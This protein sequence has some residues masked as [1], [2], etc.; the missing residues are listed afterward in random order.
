MPDARVFD[1][2]FRANVIREIMGDENKFR[3]REAWRRY[4]VYR[5][6]QDQFVEL[7]MKSEFGE[8]TTKEIRKIT[9]INLTKKICNKQASIYNEPPNRTY[10][11]ASEE[12]EKLLNDLYEKGKVNVKLKKANKYYKLMDQCTVYVLPKFGE[13]CVKVLSPH[14]YDVVPSEEDPEVGSIYVLNT[15][16][17]SDFE[18]KMDVVNQSI[19]DP[20]DYKAK[21]RRFIW[22]TDEVNFTTNQAGEV[23][24]PPKDAP[25]VLAE[26]GKS[27]MLANPIGM[28]PFIDVAYDKDYEFWVRMGK[29]KVD[30]NVD[31]STILSDWATV[32]K[33]Q[34]YAQAVVVSEEPPNNMII[35]PTRVI[36]LKTSSTTAV[37]PT[38]AFVAPAP[39]LASTLEGIKALLSL[40]LSAEGLD[41]KTI[42]GNAEGE[43]FT[44]GLERLLSMIEQFSATADDFDLFK[45]VEEKVFQLFVA[46]NNVLQGTDALSQDLAGPVLNESLKQQVA[47]AHPEL[48]QTPTEKETS[49]ILRL[50]ENLITLEEAIMELRGV[51]K[52]EAAKIIEELGKEKEKK[53]AEAQKM[54]EAQALPAPGQEGKPGG[55]GPPKS[56]ANGTGNPAPGQT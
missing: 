30:F 56:P 28:L 37:Q 2:A 12:E 14:Q 33:L 55:G 8:Q 43:K 27:G 18:I 32:A 54:M 45:Y 3:K 46:W 17:K 5:D 47:F 21:L 40:F 38:F 36:H 19:A 1:Q 31:F 34:G 52:D 7:K 16:D 6:R 26:P 9:S 44:S 51:D 23:T 20:E 29:N 10:T 41:P 53:M 42:T 25:N 24:P 39:D 22:W 11:A 35:G 50:S 15:F 48:I 4:E 49:V 13:I